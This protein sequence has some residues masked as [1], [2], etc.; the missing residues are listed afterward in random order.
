MRSLPRLVAA[1][2]TNAFTETER[3]TVYAVASISTNETHDFTMP[4]DPRLAER[5]A[6]RGAHLDGFW[7]HDA[8][9]NY[10]APAGLEAENPVWIHTAGL[11]RH[12]A[13]LA[14][15]PSCRSPARQSTK[16]WSAQPRK[17]LDNS[18]LTV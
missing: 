5:I 9:T 7:L 8:F 13:S 2:C 1:L 11:F 16:A 3:L 15:T 6:R 14:L 17:T 18:G 12:G 10:E 4:A